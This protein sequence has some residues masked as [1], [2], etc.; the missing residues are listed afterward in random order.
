LPGP[1][2]FA[3]CRSFCRPGGPDNGRLE[4]HSSIDRRTETCSQF[5]SPAARSALD[6]VRSAAHD[7]FQT[8]SPAT[9]VLFPRRGFR[10]WI[11]GKLL[12]D[13]VQ[14]EDTGDTRVVG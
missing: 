14:A 12:R 9:E 13:A 3:W 4:T 5:A 11:R 1:L 2:S 8:D 7:H 10:L 6:V